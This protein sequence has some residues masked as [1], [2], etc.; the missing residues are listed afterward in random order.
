M[1][2]ME[3]LMERVIEAIYYMAKTKETEIHH[4]ESEELTEEELTK[5]DIH[6]QVMKL[7]PVDD[8]HE[9]EMVEEE[10]AYDDEP[11]YEEVE[12]LETLEVESVEPHM[13]NQNLKIE[14]IQQTHHQS[15]QQQHQQQHQ[16]QQKI[17]NPARFVKRPRSSRSKDAS[18]NKRDRLEFDG[19]CDLPL[20]AKEIEVIENWINE[21]EHNYDLFLEKLLKIKRLN[22]DPKK[23]LRQL[24]TDNVYDLYTF[25]AEK[26]PR[27][28]RR[29][30]MRNKRI[31]TTVLQETLECSSE[32]AEEMLKREIV[33][34]R[35]RNVSRG[36]KPSGHVLSPT[37]IRLASIGGNYGLE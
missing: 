31:F 10:I 30:E 37:T 2:R 22:N 11:H 1:D 32:E 4:I 15:T 14:Y 6:R 7:Q 13:Q 9:E 16:I 29:L 20:E 25:D 19:P 28:Y 17:V 18:A 33:L 27:T 26:Q 5:E 23:V 36:L 3:A 8:M 21:S 35:K 34:G 12:T 24:F